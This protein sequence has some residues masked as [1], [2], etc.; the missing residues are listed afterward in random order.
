MAARRSG[1]PGVGVYLWF[2]GSAQAAA[3]T[4]TMWGGVGKSGSPA[5]KPITSSPAAWSAFALASTA[6]VADSVMAPTRREMRLIPTWSRTSLRR[7]PIVSVAA[8]AAS[9]AD[10]HA[11]DGP[12]G[13]VEQAG[14][15]GEDLDDGGL[16][17]EPARGE[18][19][20]RLLVPK[21]GGGRHPPPP[22]PRGGA[23]P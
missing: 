18:P 8:T 12:V 20:P 19:G 13:E 4:S 9:G 3:A 23:P 11:V 16:G 15:V 14:V 17:T 5:P 1:R 2:R 21:E 7:S 6:R 10:R 22:P